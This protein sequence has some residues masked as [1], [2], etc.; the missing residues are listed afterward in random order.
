L[1][2]DLDAPIYP[3]EEDDRLDDDVL[4]VLEAGHETAA[5]FEA[6]C[7]R[8]LGDYEPVPAATA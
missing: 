7:E 4:A 1:A 8:R 6:D 2:F 3:G 5:E